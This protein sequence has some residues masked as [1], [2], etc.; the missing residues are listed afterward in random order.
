MSGLDVSVIKRLESGTRF[1]ATLDTI[2]T[3]AHALG[4]T[5]AE[6]VTDPDLAPIK[7]E[8]STPA[9]I[10]ELIEVFEARETGRTSDRPLVYAQPEEIAWLR[11][12]DELFW[13]SCP[14]TLET[15]AGLVEAYRRRRLR[16]Q[17][18]E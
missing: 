14:P 16:N 5:T 4:V 2:E 13:A 15:L 10:V 17:Q 7:V 1:S 18:T 8:T 11:D 3:L 6:L 12:L 9:D